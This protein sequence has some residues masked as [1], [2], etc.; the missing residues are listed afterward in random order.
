[1]NENEVVHHEYHVANAKNLVAP[2]AVVTTTV[3]GTILVWR[4]AGELVK[5]PL[6]ALTRRLKKEN[7]KN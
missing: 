1:M 3:L 7:E 4:V 5:P 2:T 6:T